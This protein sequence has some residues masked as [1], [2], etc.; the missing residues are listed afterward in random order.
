LRAGRIDGAVRPWILADGFISLLDLCP[1][2]RDCSASFPDVAG[3]WLIAVDCGRPWH[4]LRW[5]PS[6]GGDLFPHLVIVPCWMMTC[7]G[8]AAA[9]QGTVCINFPELDYDVSPPGDDLGP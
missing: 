7:T 6:R 4:D 1:S 2:V 8:Q 5:E 3:L 9:D